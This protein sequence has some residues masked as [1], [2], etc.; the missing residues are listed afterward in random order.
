[1]VIDD[2]STNQNFL[3]HHYKVDEDKEVA[4][5]FKQLIKIYFTLFTIFILKYQS[6]G[7]IVP[8][9]QVFLLAN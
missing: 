8:K 3:I 2:A 4:T 6:F 9:I 7:I 5:L 1:M